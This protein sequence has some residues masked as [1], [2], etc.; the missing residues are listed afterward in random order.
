[1]SINELVTD[2]FDSIFIRTDI[3][4]IQ[5]FNLVCKTWNN[6]IL[7]K[8]MRCPTCNKIIK[9]YGTDLYITDTYCLMCHSHPLVNSNTYELANYKIHNIKIFQTVLNLLSDMQQFLFIS[10]EMDCI[11]ISR[12]N[13]DFSLYIKLSKSANQLDLFT[14]HENTLNFGISSKTFLHALLQL[15]KIYKSEHDLNSQ[16]LTLSVYGKSN[17]ITDIMLK[18]NNNQSKI[19]VNHVHSSYIFTYIPDFSPDV[20]ITIN[21]IQFN[22]ICMASLATNI[23]IQWRINEL[24]FKYD[25][26]IKFTFNTTTKNMGYNIYNT[27]QLLQ[28]SKIGLLSDN[29]ILHLKHTH[30]IIFITKIKNFG[31]IKFVLYTSFN[32]KY[33]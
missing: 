14:F 17:N 13:T 4:N 8:S 25:D 2:I 16:I 24:I 18:I 22:K 33:L 10:I 19:Q 29:V 21:S 15:S 27:N 1:M 28:F 31:K 12:Q 7:S 20:N 9:I 3:I 30:A 11:K 6:I 5:T 23:N 32:I 26:S